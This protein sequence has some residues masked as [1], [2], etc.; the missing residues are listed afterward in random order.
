M[1]KLWWSLL[2]MLAI[3]GV[4]NICLGLGYA[5]NIDPN[6]HLYLGTGIILIFAVMWFSVL[7]FKGGRW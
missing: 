1:D 6:V 3:M 4:A 2:G 5:F 7:V